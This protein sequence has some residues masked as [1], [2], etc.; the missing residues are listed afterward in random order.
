MSVADTGGP[1]AVMVG[2]QK[3]RSWELYSAITGTRKALWEENEQ[4]QKAWKRLKGAMAEWRVGGEAKI[5]K[6][7]KIVMRNSSFDPLNI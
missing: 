1:A 2:K 3:G 4:D 5:A 7:G 6:N